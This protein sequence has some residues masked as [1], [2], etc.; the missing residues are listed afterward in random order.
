[1]R[2]Y[3]VT[4]RLNIPVFGAD[5]SNPTIYDY[6]ANVLGNPAYPSFVGMSTR[7]T[8][9]DGEHVLVIDRGSTGAHLLKVT[10]LKNNEINRIPLNVTGVI[11]GTYTMNMGAQVNG[12]TYMAS[13]STSGTNPLKI[14]H[15][16][17]P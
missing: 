9:F 16:T 2:E 7:G 11:G 8:G 17:D 14:Y 3:L 4:L 6:S 12:H 1:Y 13:L 15:W 5:F 10:D